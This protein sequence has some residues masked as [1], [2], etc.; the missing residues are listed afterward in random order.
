MP[1]IDRRNKAYKPAAPAKVYSITLDDE[2]HARAVKARERM[3][4]KF[5]DKREEGHGAKKGSISRDDEIGGFAGELAAAI[6]L[7]VEWTGEACDTQS[8]DIGT[9]TQV[10]TLTRASSR[11]LLV[12]PY[13][14]RKYGNV[15]F[16][17][18]RMQEDKRTFTILGWCMGDEVPQ[19]GELTDG[20]NP[21]R[22]LVYL[23]DQ[24]NL[25]RAEYLR[26]A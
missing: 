23:V 4:A 13:D 11:R 8:A 26:L 20:G 3:D 15:P 17:L 22:P 7:G 21:D 5:R 6:L 12:R 18:V 2:Q 9:R 16:V 25:R 24:N 1:L 14:L 10:R 19:R